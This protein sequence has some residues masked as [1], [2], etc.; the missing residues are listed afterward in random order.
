MRCRWHLPG[1]GY[2]RGTSGS[3]NLLKWSSSKPAFW[4]R[5]RNYLYLPGL[6]IMQTFLKRW[7]EE[8][9][10]QW[11]RPEDADD[12]D[13]RSNHRTLLMLIRYRALY[14]C[15]LIRASFYT[16]EIKNVIL[17]LANKEIEARV[18]NE[19]AYLHIARN[20]RCGVGGAFQTVV[21]SSRACEPTCNSA[22]CSF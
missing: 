13:E 3:R 1:L 2:G 9:K 12:I 8:L 16:N 5:R 21:S 20:Q 6:F 22:V 19:L 10:G 7:W 18:V 15:F 4:P 17:P 14:M 11:R